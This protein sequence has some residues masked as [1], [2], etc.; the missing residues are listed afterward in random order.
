MATRNG[1][2]AVS[3]NDCPV[4]K[5]SEPKPQAARVVLVFART[6]LVIL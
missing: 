2:I 1:I 5:L 4:L 6:K 3:I